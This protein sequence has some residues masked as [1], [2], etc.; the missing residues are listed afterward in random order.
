MLFVFCLICIAGNLLF[1]WPGSHVYAQASAQN[2]KEEEALYVGKKAFE[3]GFY[4]VSLGLFER[5]IKNF[6]LSPRTPEVNLLIGQCYL[7]QGRFPEALAQFEMLLNDPRS[8]GIRDAALYWMAEVHFKVNNFSKARGFYKKIIDDFPDSRYAAI[9]YYS[10]GWC[11]FQEHLYDEAMAYYTVVE[12]RFPKETFAKESSFKIIECL[13]NLK[14]YAS[15][16]EKLKNYIKLYSHD[17][18]KL[19]HLY[20]YL[21]EADYYLNNF[22]ES[23]DSYAKAAA[24]TPDKRITALSKLGQGWAFLKMKKYKDADQAFSDVKENELEKPSREAFLLGKAVLFTETDNNPAAEG[25][26]DQLIK[27]A[28]DP[29]ILIQAYLGKADLLYN[30]SKYQE[31]VTIYKEAQSKLGD[32]IPAEIVDK[33]YYGLAWSYLKEGQF[34]EAIDGFQKIA[35][36]SED[37]IVKVSAL[38][39]VGDA[40]QDSGDYQKAA[41]AYD[42]ILKDYPDSL[43]SDYVQYQLGLSLLKSLNYNGAA[44]AFQSLKRNFPGSKLLDD[45]SYALG[46]SYFQREDYVSSNEVFERFQ[47]EFKDSILRAQAM[48]LWGSSLYNLGKFNEAIEVFKN[49]IKS[50]GQDTEL[51]Q[52]AEYEIADCFY[53]RG[54]EAEAMSRFKAL[55]AKYPDSKLTS[56]VIWWLG[57]Y[58]Y[59]HNELALARRYF[60]SLVQDFPKSNLV[61][62]A[63]YA[64]GSTYEEESEYDSALEY[65]KKVVASGKSDLAGTALVAMADIYSAQDKIDLALK[66]YKDVINDYPNL[67][68]LVFPK[69]ASVYRKAGDLDEAARYYEKSLDIVPVNEMSRMQFK[70]AE[71]KEAQGKTG[72][73]IDDY[74]KVTYLYSHDNSLVVKALLRVAAIYENKENIKEAVKVYE[75]VASMD[76]EE[77]KYAKEKLDW[78][79][80]NLKSR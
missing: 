30:A 69:L 60:S 19:P 68:A 14:D 42:I 57:E 43:Y 53:R 11:L 62:N 8:K 40:Y 73:A 26:Y 63:N 77:A 9:S 49:I 76:A 3:D 41:E 47:N 64:L 7:H 51:V 45:A 21:A 23:V 36:S 39:Q 4:E 17:T 20:F 31:A 18:A 5:F 1:N 13:Y 46:L 71:I 58:Y 35:K 78:I 75:R 34:K 2:D 29:V 72:Q 65:F 27:S 32:G 56:E 61:P 24:G 50:Y 12:E 59:R 10:L 37:K 79:R 55:R 70:L 16:K 33:L 25:V 6:P 80:G 15:L 44:L 38:C 28:L 54:D 48:Y 22:Q 52:K 66:T 67:L 74:M